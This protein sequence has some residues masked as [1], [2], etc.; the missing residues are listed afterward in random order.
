M[1]RLHVIVQRYV[2]RWAIE[3]ALVAAAVQIYRQTMELRSR[4]LEHPIMVRVEHCPAVAYWADYRRGA[5]A[6]VLLA[7]GNRE[8]DARNAAGPGNRLFRPDTRGDAARP[9]AHLFLL[10]SVSLCH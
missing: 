5:V 2:P 8:S 7:A 6:A 1:P 10:P 4:V 3:V 9:L